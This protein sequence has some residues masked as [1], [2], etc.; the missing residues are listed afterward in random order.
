[1][2]SSEKP[3]FSPVS[4]RSTV[5][6]TRPRSGT[7]LVVATG[8]KIFPSPLEVVRGVVE[9]AR[10]GSLCRATSAT[11]SVRVACGYVL[12]LVLGIPLGLALGW[13]PAAARG[14]ESADPDAAA[15][16]A[17]G[18]DAARVV[19]WF[20]VSNV[21]P[22]FLIFLASFFPIVVATMNGVRNVPP[23]YLSGRPQL[24]VVGR[25]RC[26]RG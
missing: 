7:W 2:P 15:D 23:M 8:T 22:I 13:Y 5:A 16:L 10:K 3:G 11:R 18:V 24:R 12:A 6:A 4:C 1:M 19:I 25:R 14:A 20:G 9:L 17:A 21:A 26:S